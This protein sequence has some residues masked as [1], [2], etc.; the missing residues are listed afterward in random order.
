MEIV[1]TK[2]SYDTPPYTTMRMLLI[3]SIFLLQSLSPE[4]RAVEGALYGGYAFERKVTMIGG[5][6]QDVH[7]TLDMESHE[8]TM[9]VRGASGATWVAI[10]LSEYGSMKG[11]DVAM[12]K[13][14]QN[15]DDDESSFVVEDLISHDF[16][17]PQNDI[18]QSVELLYAHIDQEDRLQAII[19]RRLDTCDKDDIAIE[20]YRQYLVGASG[21]VNAKG[22]AVF[23]G[24]SR[25]RAVVIYSWTRT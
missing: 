10:G 11:L 2:R 19:R 7:W 18:L 20:P 5:G 21:D 3:I 25:A 1:A 24:P 16:V 8:I 9:A 17:T 23:H 6:C 12:I 13:E 22:E 14:L 4:G 15:E